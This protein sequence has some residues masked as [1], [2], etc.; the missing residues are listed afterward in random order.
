MAI[1]PFIFAG[2]Q[3]VNPLLQTL[4]MAPI[5]IPNQPVFNMLT[6]VPTVTPE[7]QNR[8]AEIEARLAELRKQRGQ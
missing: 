5:Q 2:Q 1:E 3:G 6:G 4:C 7:L 8:R